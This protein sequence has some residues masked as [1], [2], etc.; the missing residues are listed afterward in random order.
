MRRVA[1]LADIHG[2]A[3]ALQAVLAE[4][5]RE[6][7][8]VVVLNGDLADGPMPVQTLELLEGLGDRAVWVRGNTDRW[9]VDAYDG[10]LELPGLPTNPSSGWFTWC[11]GQL[12]RAHRDRLADLPLIVSLEIDGL[13]HVAFCHATARDD[14]EFVLVDSPVALFRDAFAKL[15][16]PTVVLGHTHMPFD[17]L[18]DG[19]RFVNSGSVGLGYGHPGASWLLL[20]PDVALRRT[21]Y[22]AQLVAR[23]LAQAAAGLPGI[24]GVT[25]NVLHP[26]SDAEALAAFTATVDAQQSTDG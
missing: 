4:L 15:D 10:R 13:G 3:P 14:N 18:A 9:L 16:E 8:D 23:T 20:G 21:N 19:R 25:R 17:R 1:V 6:D 24:E 11:A 22:D 12:E 26:D 2:N 5:E 7:V